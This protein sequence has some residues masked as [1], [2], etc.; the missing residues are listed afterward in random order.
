MDIRKQIF[1]DFVNSAP[2]PHYSLI[3]IIGS[4]ATLFSLLVVTLCLLAGIVSLCAALAFVFSREKRLLLLIL[5][6][7]IVGWMLYGVLLAGG[8][9]SLGFWCGVGLLAGS[10]PILKRI[11][12]RRIERRL[13]VSS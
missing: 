12:R 2:A 4:F 13:A 1:E 8:L 11:A 5:V 6:P 3:E 10:Y 9:T 7:Q